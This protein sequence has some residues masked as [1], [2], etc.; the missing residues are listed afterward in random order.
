MIYEK[1][2]L[3]NNIT[4][5]R[6]KWQNT[7]ILLLA[8]HR[9]QKYDIIAI[10][11]SWRNLNNATLLS[12]HRSDFHLLYKSEADIRVC[13]YINEKIDFNSWEIEYSS[14]N[15]CM[16]KLKITISSKKKMIFVY[17]V[18]NFSLTSYSARD[19]L[20]ILLLA[21]L[22]LKTSNE[23]YFLTNSIYIIHT[24]AT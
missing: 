6:Q 1:K 12:F 13:L 7:M 5:Q 8:N 22:A 17:N 3:F 19:S 14:S 15:I 18:Y 4:V 20:S 11:K 24:K 9:I 21:T 16:L 10:Q 23:H 2:S